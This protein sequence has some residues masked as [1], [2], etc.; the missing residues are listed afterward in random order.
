MLKAYAVAAVLA[1]ATPAAVNAE[2]SVQ[3]PIKSKA[4]TTK[5]VA[6]SKSAVRRG[7]VRFAVRRGTVRF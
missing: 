6:T 2:E 4:T 7:T 5:T 3:A 1:T